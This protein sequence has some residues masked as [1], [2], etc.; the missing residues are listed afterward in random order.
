MIKENI[1]ASCD[2]ICST[3]RVGKMPVNLEPS[4]NIPTSWFSV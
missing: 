4:I 1:K 2:L 3:V